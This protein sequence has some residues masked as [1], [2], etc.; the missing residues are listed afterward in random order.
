MTSPG[1]PLTTLGGA[2]DQYDAM[3]Q[4]MIDAATSLQPGDDNIDEETGEEL[5]DGGN[6]G[7]PAVN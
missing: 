1:N 5:E 7:L 4:A 2:L 6:R 3:Q